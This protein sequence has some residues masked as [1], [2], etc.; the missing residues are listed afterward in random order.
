MMEKTMLSMESCAFR[1][2]N[3]QCFEIRLPNGKTIITDPCYDYPENP[4]VPLADLFRLREFTTDDIEHCDYVILNHT[5]GDHIANLGELIRKFSPTVICH[6]G[7]AAEVAQAYKDMEL[8]S[9]YGVDYNGTYYFDGF[10]METFH[11]EHKP[12]RFTWQ[13]SMAEG[14][15]ISQ[16]PDLTRLHAQG[17]LFNLNYLLTFDNGFRLAFVGGTDDGMDERLRTLRPDIALRNKITNAMD[18][19]HVAQDWYRFMERC[20]AQM[21]VPMHFEVWENQ[22]PGFSGQTFVRANEMAEENRLGCRI[23]APERTE[24]YSVKMNVI[25]VK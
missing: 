11:G 24:W 17:G 22:Q 16:N 6:T 1:W 8:T 23:L 2:I 7:V 12:Q 19:E 3:C 14:D 9:I 15:V 21:V 13:Q 18:V 4:N 25:H 10:F 20:H 5:H